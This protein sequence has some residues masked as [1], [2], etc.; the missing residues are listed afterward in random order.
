MS[1]IITTLYYNW[2]NEVV[3]SVSV[4]EKD[5]FKILEHRSEHAGDKWYYDIYYT[6]GKVKRTFNPNEV[7]WSDQNG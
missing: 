5:V 6:D 1:K 4:E 2:T 3:E 7:I